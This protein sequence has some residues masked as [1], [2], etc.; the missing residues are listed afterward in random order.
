MGGRVGASPTQLRILS[1]KIKFVPLPTLDSVPRSTSARFSFGR[2]PLIPA[3]A[4]HGMQ[5]TK[6]YY[7]YG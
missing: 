3:T 7:Y 4:L 6:T 5:E 1:D 2:W